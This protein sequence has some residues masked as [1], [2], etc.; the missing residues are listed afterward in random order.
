M[1][2]QTFKFQSAKP[3][4]TRRLLNQKDLEKEKKRSSMAGSSVVI[5]CIS[6]C[7]YSKSSFQTSSSAHSHSIRSKKDTRDKSRCKCEDIRA[8]NKLKTKVCSIM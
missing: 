4:T 1:K 3:T 2:W 7:I 5:L 6:K 8:D